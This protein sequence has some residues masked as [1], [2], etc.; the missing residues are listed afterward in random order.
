MYWVRGPL[1]SEKSEGSSHSEAFGEE[2]STGPLALGS[3][4]AGSSRHEVLSYS[5][6]KHYGVSMRG[7]QRVRQTRRGLRCC[8]GWVPRTGVRRGWG[9]GSSREGG[10]GGVL[11]AFSCAVQQFTRNGHRIVAQ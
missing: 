5:P 2:A 1:S 7:A 3:Y 9:W 4:G 10:Q 8:L 11:L 6:G